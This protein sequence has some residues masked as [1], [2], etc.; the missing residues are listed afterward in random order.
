[1]DFQY[2]SDIHLDYQVNLP[3]IIPK[4]YNLIL[5]GNIGDPYNKK[6]SDF[7]YYISEL[8]EKVFIISGNYEYYSTFRTMKEID[9]KIKDIT[10]CKI[11]LFFLQNESYHFPNSNLSVYG[12]TLWKDEPKEYKYIP[13][14]SFNKSLNLYNQSMVGLYNEM[15]KN[16]SKVWIV[17]CHNIPKLIDMPLYNQKKILG[18]V[19]GNMYNNKLDD[20]YYC[21]LNIEFNKIFCV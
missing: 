15:Q 8:F 20:K 13:F 14:M 12:S 9:N 6:Y 5:A 16:D 11:N 18:V 2:I 21:N 3:K 17:I 7:L 19:Y 10:K 4:A 1:M